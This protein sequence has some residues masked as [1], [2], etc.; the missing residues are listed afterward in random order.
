MVLQEP[1][2]NPMGNKLYFENWG[3]EI[4]DDLRSLFVAD[5][6][7]PLAAASLAALS[8][9]GMSDETI[10]EYFAVETRD[11]AKLRSRYGL[12]ETSG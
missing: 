9:L 11:V 10:A 4:T 6:D 8:D 3:D 2:G 5:E 12:A 7:W 1:R